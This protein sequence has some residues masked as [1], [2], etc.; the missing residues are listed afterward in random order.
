MPLALTLTPKKYL[1]RPEEG[2]HSFTVDGPATITVFEVNHNGKV[3]VSI[4]ADP[5]VQIVRDN[6]KSTENKHGGHGG[7]Q[8]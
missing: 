1:A 4:E 8:R 7:R 6:A 5:E 2:G 3:R